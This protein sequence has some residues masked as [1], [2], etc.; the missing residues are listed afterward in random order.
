MHNE[1]KNFFYRSHE[2]NRW[3]VVWSFTI[4]YVANICCRIELE[5]SQSIHHKCDYIF[6]IT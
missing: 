1:K 3:F 2:T 4:T 6:E 5:Q